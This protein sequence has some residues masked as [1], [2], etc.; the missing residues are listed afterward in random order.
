MLKSAGKTLISTVDGA[1]VPLY[2]TAFVKAAAAFAVEDAG[3][4]QAVAG[5]EAAAA[6]ARALGRSATGEKRMLDAL[7]PAASAVRA[8]LDGGDG[9]EEI[10]AAASA[11][12][13]TGVQATVH[14]LATKGRA[15]YLGERSIGHQD[16]GATS[17]ALLRRALS[18]TLGAR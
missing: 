7:L 12:A 11:A 17:A 5:L 13:D 10:L 9:L 8:A 2:G 14:M 4:E 18:E 3:R 16:P 1:S 15:S 6:G